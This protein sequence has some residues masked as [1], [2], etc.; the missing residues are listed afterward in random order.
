MNILITDIMFPN[1]YS[2]WR[3]EEIRS[4]IV[5]KSA[6]ILILNR[7]NHYAGIDFPV[8]FDF[9]NNSVVKLADYNILI[10]DETFNYLNQ[11]NKRI[12]GT[13]FNNKYFGS[14]LLTKAECFCVQNYDLIYH[15]FL[16]N[17]NYFNKFYDFPQEKQAIHLILVVG[18]V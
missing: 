7:V 18:T 13:T 17:Y 4:Y 9:I 1:K 8:D 10:F 16:M 15:I 5:D 2:R 3:N 11:F 14:Y 6:D 12:D